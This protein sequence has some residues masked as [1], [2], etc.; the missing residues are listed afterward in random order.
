MESIILKLQLTS[1]HSFLS[2]TM[3]PNITDQ[4]KRLL[5]L[6]LMRK[7]SMETENLLKIG[8]KLKILAASLPSKKQANML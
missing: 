3:K 4:P 7:F 6:K 1:S 5:S 2:K 8:K